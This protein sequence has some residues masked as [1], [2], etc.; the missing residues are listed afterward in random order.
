MKI[1]TLLIFLLS[2]GCSHLGVTDDEFCEQEPSNE[3]CVDPLALDDE[4]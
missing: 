4:E 3:M 1:I 2:V